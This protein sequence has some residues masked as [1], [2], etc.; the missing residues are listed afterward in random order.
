MTIDYDAIARLFQE[1]D[2]VGA[3]SSLWLRIPRKLLSEGRPVGRIMV[4]TVT[5]DEK[6]K[7][8]FGALTFTHK[9]RL[10][11]W[12]VLPVSANML[13][14]GTTV[15]TPDHVT[16]ELPSKKMHITGY[17]ESGEP[18]HY[19]PPRGSPSCGE[20]SRAW[21]AKKLPNCREICLWFVVMIRTAVIR[22]QELAV[23]RLVEMPESDRA[24]RLAE[25][26][27]Y[28]KGLQFVDVP[29]PLRVDSDYICCAVALSSECGDKNVPGPLFQHLNSLAEKID[30]W[31]ADFAEVQSQCALSQHTVYFGTACPAGTLKDAV[32][33]G[34]PRAIA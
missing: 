33:L 25:V 29:F 6:E 27:C 34:L 13:A 28:I 31:S 18:N 17:Q 4:L 7:R 10:I 1:Q 22:E 8:P 21:K 12:P 5:L 20:G 15:A 24:R 32:Y 2:S 26:D 3:N 23:Q 14:P 11:F 30:G 19:P 9:N 16:L